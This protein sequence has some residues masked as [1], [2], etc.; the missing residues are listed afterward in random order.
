MLLVATTVLGGAGWLIGRRIVTA[1]AVEADLREAERLQQQSALPEA[2]AALERARSRLGD[3]GPF[4]L[5][6]V[7]EGG[8]PRS[9]VPGTARG[10]PHDSIDLRGGA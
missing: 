3:G 10:D 8:P 6:P 9:A 1:R 4:W 5:Y 7:V 2:G